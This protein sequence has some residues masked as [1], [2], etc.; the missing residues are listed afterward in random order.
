MCCVVLYLRGLFFFQ[1]CLLLSC[2]VSLF[3][4]L[5]FVRFFFPTCVHAP[6]LA[7]HPSIAVHSYAVGWRRQARAT[8]AWTQPDRLHRGV[9][10]RVAG[11]EQQRHTRTSAFVSQRA[12]CCGPRCVGGRG[13]GRGRVSERW[14]TVVFSCDGRRLAGGL[15][16]H[17]STLLLSQHTLCLLLLAQMEAWSTPSPLE[18]SLSAP[19]VS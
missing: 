18:W 17:V 13:S 3:R 2:V 16:S 8:H 1:C 5:H 12:Q 14:C 4:F 15:F 9:A 19:T 7:L 6:S 11:S 10:A